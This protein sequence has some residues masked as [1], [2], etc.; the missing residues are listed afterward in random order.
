MVDRDNERMFRIEK[1]TS[2]IVMLVLLVSY[3][4]Y[5]DGPA[6]NGIDTITAIYN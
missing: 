4:L 6:D 1:K 5:G 2:G 3:F